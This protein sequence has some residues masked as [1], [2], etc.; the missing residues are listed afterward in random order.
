[1]H[2]Y[3]GSASVINDF[4]VI[5]ICHWHDFIDDQDDH[6]VVRVYSLSTNSW[7]TK[8]HLIPYKSVL[9]AFEQLDCPSIQVISSRPAFGHCFLKYKFHQSCHWWV[10]G[11]LCKGVLAFDMAAESF[12]LIN[13]A[14]LPK[15]HYNCLT[16]TW[17]LN[18]S[19]AY[20]CSYLDDPYG[21]I[22]VWIM[23]QYGVKDS[24]VMSYSS[25]VMSYSFKPIGM[26]LV[27]IPN[28]NQIFFHNN[29][30]QLVASTFGDAQVYKEHAIYGI[31]EITKEILSR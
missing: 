31:E 17:V 7:K 1:M 9:K 23:M 19:L 18:K 28:D 12:Q 30:G 4:K 22:E 2:R 5:V 15:H 20:S 13:R 6:W 16:S 14:P 25:W 8:H 11:Q 29:N 27:G 21:T 10:V 26:S 24:W 3:C